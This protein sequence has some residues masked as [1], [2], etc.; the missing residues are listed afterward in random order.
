MKLANN[1]WAILIAILL[2]A[3][4]CAQFSGFQ[5]GRTAGKGGGEIYLALAAVNTAAD[6]NFE[7]DSSSFETGSLLIPNLEA[8]GRYGVGERF[9]IGLRFSTSLSFLVD[10][11]YQLVG[12]QESLFAM[13]VGGT[14]GYQGFAVVGLWQGQ[15]P[16]FFSLHPNEKLAFYFSP[17]YITQFSSALEA[18]SINYGSFSTGAEFGERVKFVVDFSLAKILNEQELF[19]VLNFWQVGIGVKFAF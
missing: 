3:P 16:L 13:S 8:G 1:S 10:A 11:K 12:D 15:I 2:I 7:S 9:D 6:I 5:T 14:I 4:G 18:G 19:D 17:K